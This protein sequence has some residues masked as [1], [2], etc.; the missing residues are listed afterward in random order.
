MSDAK[1]ATLLAQTVLKIAG[2]DIPLDGIMGPLTRQAYARAQSGVKAKVDATLSRDTPFSS[3]GNL[4]KSVY[5]GGVPL[6]PA[7]VAKVIDT[8]FTTTPIQN[9]I[10]TPD[11]VQKFISIE[12]GY[13]NPDATNG[14]YAGLM[15]MGRGA[16]EDA[17]DYDPGIGSY[18]A[19]KF[20]PVLNVRAG[21]G[22][23][24]SNASALRDAG[25]RGPITTDILY[26]AHNQGPGWLID[27]WRSG[28][29]ADVESLMS[30]IVGDN[31]S[32]A[33]IFANA[34]ATMDSAQQV[35]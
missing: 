6:T 28:T 31:R 3:F 9:P 32:V 16:W 24:Q 13:L 25:Y 11:G 10:L 12:D 8:A 20:N 26:T 30:H 34:L 33:P 29:P 4:V 18:D 17:R 14:P 19:G 27:Q 2:A 35:A 15:Q 7:L 23:A 1:N 5:H 22:Y 21:M